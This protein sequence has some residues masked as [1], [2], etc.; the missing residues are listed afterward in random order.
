M[1]TAS[2]CLICV[3]SK[4]VSKCRDCTFVSCTKCIINWFNTSRGFKC[5]QCKKLKT[6]N[7][8]YTQFPEFVTQEEVYEDV[9]DDDEDDTGWE[10]PP[11]LMAIANAL[12]HHDRGHDHDHI[13]PHIHHN[14][15][16][17]ILAP[18]HLTEQH[19]RNFACCN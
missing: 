4:N 11:T 6:Y 2:T 15:L 3:R 7:I 5:P 13:P 16:A 9:I 14:I 17:H 19:I 8:D 18:L 10:E 1:A 12:H